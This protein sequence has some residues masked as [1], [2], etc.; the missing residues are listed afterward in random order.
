MLLPQH[1][2]IMK[3]YH[4]V[5]GCTANKSDAAIAR[6]LII[7][8]SSYELVDTVQEA[9]IILLLT[10]TVISTTEQK[11][12]SKINQYIKQ[13]KTV[14]LSGC[15]ASIQK[16]L[17]NQ[18]DERIICIPPQKIHHLISFLDQSSSKNIQGEKYDTEKTFSSLHAPIAIAEGCAFSCA[19]CITTFARGKLKSYPIETIQKDFESALQQGCKEIQLTAQDTASYGLDK[20]VSLVMLLQR[21]QNIP[22]SYR[23]RIGMMNP[24][25]AYSIVDDLITC[26]ENEHVYKFLHVP[27]Q[28]GS[29]SILEK[30]NRKYT[31]E[32]AI[33]IIKKFRER[34][35][36]ITIATDIIVGFPTETD[37]QFQQSLQLIKDLKPDIVNITKFSARPYTKAKKMKGRIPTNVVKKRSQQLT[38]IT[39]KI[40]LEKN[41][42][43]IGKTYN[44]LIT[45]KGKNETMIGRAENYKPVVLHE[46]IPIGSWT[47]IKVIE[48]EQTYLVG[49]LK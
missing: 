26:Y 2:R 23:I 49:M 11:I 45:E 10:C 30:M 20:N 16:E 8:H 3:I 41:L 46:K 28:S 12:I 18:I 34:I 1:I 40:S 27:I 14:V 25:T 32:K 33:G 15:M 4:D 42:D 31:V 43:R 29:N 35:D 47:D 17:I 22:G 44:V 13:G 48:A 5:Y 36:D 21:L 7:H 38:D 39:Q 24:H 9:D 6:N 37:E 19:Y